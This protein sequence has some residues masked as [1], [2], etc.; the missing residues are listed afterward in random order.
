[1]Y[2]ILNEVTQELQTN[3][4]GNTKDTQLLKEKQ[5]DEEGIGRVLRNCL[6]F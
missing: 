4:K 6:G 5:R 2:E 3:S 1:M